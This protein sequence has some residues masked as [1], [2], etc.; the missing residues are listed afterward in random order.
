MLDIAVRNNSLNIINDSWQDVISSLL[1]ELIIYNPAPCYEEE[2][3]KKIIDAYYRAFDIHGG[4]VDIE[5]VLNEIYEYN[6]DIFIKVSEIEAS[7]DPN[8][9]TRKDDHLYE[10]LNDKI[11]DSAEGWNECYYYDN[12]LYLDDYVKALFYQNRF[13]YLNPYSSSDYIYFN[14][15]TIVF[16]NC[17]NELFEDFDKNYLET[18]HIRNVDDLPQSIEIQDYLDN[19]HNSYDVT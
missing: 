13:F 9:F 19:Y 11:I 16:N 17:Q 12:F 10:S 7:Y 18:P 1:L 4:K 8:F 5:D 3:N 15:E 2:N 6:Y 14:D